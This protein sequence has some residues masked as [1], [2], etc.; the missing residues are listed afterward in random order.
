MCKGIVTALLVFGL[1]ACAKPEVAAP[2]ASGLAPATV[3]D[4][5]YCSIR[6]RR[7]VKA[8]LDK[9]KQLDPE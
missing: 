7:Q 8:R 1:S 6:K 5:C 4:E 3:D 2:T 9:K